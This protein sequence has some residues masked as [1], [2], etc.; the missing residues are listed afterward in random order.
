MRNRIFL[1]FAVKSSDAWMLLSVIQNSERGEHACD[2]DVRTAVFISPRQPGP[3]LVSIVPWQLFHYD[4]IQTESNMK[5]SLILKY[6]L[7]QCY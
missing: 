2:T 4:Y 7:F 6:T 1:L 3:K 5:S